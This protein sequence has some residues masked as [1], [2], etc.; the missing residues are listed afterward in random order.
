VSYSPLDIMMLGLYGC[1]DGSCFRSGHE[2]ACAKGTLLSHPGS[3][4]IAYS[5]YPI[6]PKLPLF[7]NKHIKSRCIGVCDGQSFMTTNHYGM[8][9]TQRQQ[10]IKAVAEYMLEDEIDEEGSAKVTR[11]LQ[12]EPIIFS[13]IEPYYTSGDLVDDHWENPFYQNGD[14]LYWVT[15]NGTRY[16]TPTVNDWPNLCDI[17][18]D[19]DHRAE[20][21]ECGT[22]GRMGELMPEH[23][24]NIVYGYCGRCIGE[25]TRGYQY[26]ALSRFDMDDYEVREVS[27]MMITEDFEAW[28]RDSGCFHELPEAIR[29][30]V[31][32]EEEEEDVSDTDDSDGRGAGVS[33]ISG[34]V[35]GYQHGFDW[36]V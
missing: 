29:Q 8:G 1:D 36:T 13:E 34:E 9:E 20:C 26:W 19:H 4:I 12:D 22:S 35:E 33:G 25:F 32:P 27:R 21:L 23:G 16:D 3:F 24:H 10:Y 17:P 2:Y 28:A 7:E 30:T 11:E 6:D 31:R 14:A 5:D 15:D 18:L